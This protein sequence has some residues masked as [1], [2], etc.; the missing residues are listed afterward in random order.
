MTNTS[1]R[2]WHKV[3]VLDIKPGSKLL[4]FGK[5]DIFLS[6][7][8]SVCPNWWEIC[9]QF[10][11]FVTLKTKKQTSQKIEILADPCFFLQVSLMLFQEVWWT[12][13]PKCIFARNLN[14]L[15][16]PCVRPGG[17]SLAGDSELGWIFS[18]KFILMLN[19]NWT[20]GLLRPLMR[21][22]FAKTRDKLEE[23]YSADLGTWGVAIRNGC[24][25]SN[26][27]FLNVASFRGW[28]K[29]FS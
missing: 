16:E 23:S 15:H 3:Q 8:T 20:W 7:I 22:K 19:L 14:H 24:F 13:L 1:H 12:I 18:Q 25:K 9:S 2:L 27:L 4:E 21:P 11:K 26:S 28:W 17:C 29:L 5:K 6:R 10:K